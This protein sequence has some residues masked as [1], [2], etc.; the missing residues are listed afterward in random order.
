[1]KKYDLLS[2]ET[3][4]EIKMKKICGDKSESR[5]ACEVYYNGNSSIM[6]NC[7]TDNTFDLNKEGAKISIYNGYSQYV[8]FNY[9]SESYITCKGINKCNEGK[10]ISIKISLLFLFSMLFL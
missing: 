7:L 4:T 8:E 3:F 5:A 6:L 10:N 9:I 1:M 2:S